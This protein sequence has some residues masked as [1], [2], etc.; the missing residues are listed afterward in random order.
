MNRNPILVRKISHLTDARYFAAMGVDWMSIELHQDH[1]S[2]SLWHTLK[3]WIE[4]VKLAA[5]IVSD[6]EMLLAKTI[7]DAVP[8]GII[9]NQFIFPDVPN[10]IKMF[11]E[12]DMISPLNAKG[13]PT[14]ILS[15]EI[16]MLASGKILEFPSDKIFLQSSWSMH[17]LLTLL[18][19]GYKGGI[20]FSGGQ[21]DQTG[22]RD[23]G[24]MDDLLGLLS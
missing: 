20:C 13:D 9:L 2:F 12:T 5:E 10:N 18:D 15:F 23:Y 17:S 24:L 3:E 16:N 8:N 14:V 7:I 11:Y 19:S 21:E 1:A 4:G 6:D 22:V